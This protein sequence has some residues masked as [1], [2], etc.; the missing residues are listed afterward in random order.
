MTD[1][2][3]GGLPMTNYVLANTQGSVAWLAWDSNP[4]PVL[5][6]AHPTKRL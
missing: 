5:S 1:G 6:A 2:A 3:L 4:P